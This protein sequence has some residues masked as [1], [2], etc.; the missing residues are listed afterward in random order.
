MK[1]ANVKY[2]PK[3]DMMVDIKECEIIMESN[4][5]TGGG[6]RGERFHT[7]RGENNNRRTAAVP[8]WTSSF[9]LRTLSRITRFR[10]GR[11]R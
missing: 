9:C 2:R 4:M 8:S 1:I 5:Q 11:P 7:E 10:S 3:R 6:G